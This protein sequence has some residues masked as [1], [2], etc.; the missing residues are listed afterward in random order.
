[1]A[2]KCTI[3][4]VTVLL[5]APLAALHTAGQERPVAGKASFDICS[6]GATGD[7]KTLNTAAIQKAINACHAAGGGRVVVPAGVFLTGSVR[8][9]SRVVLRI[10]AG[11]T[12]RGSPDIREYGLETAPLNWGGW[13]KFVSHQLAPCLIYAEDA[14]QIG[15]EGQGTV[16]GQGGRLRKVFPNAGDSRRPMLVRFQHC[17]GVTVRDLT[18]LDPASFTTFFVR[19]RDIAIEGVTIRSRETGNGDGLDF[20]GWTLGQTQA[21]YSYLLGVFLRTKA[22][23]R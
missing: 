2:M 20:D 4:T 12:L 6:F 19:S 7:G 10:E 22:N 23:S 13:W 14:E 8:L 1:M 15:L 5:L 21:S 3:L 17:R 18:L 11:A 16:D 9:K